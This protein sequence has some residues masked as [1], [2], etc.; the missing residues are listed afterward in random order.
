MAV[1]VVGLDSDP[2]IDA[3][4]SVLRV[5]GL[6]QVGRLVRESKASVGN[7][8]HRSLL[9]HGRLAVDIHLVRHRDLHLPHSYRYV[10]TV[11]IPDVDDLVVNLA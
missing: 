1:P 11:K 7:I 5:V 4:Y 9:S 10:P 3:A 6:E 2:G 8:V